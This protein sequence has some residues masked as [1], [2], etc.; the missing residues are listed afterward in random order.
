MCKVIK[1]QR[2]QYRN[3]REDN[4]KRVLGIHTTATGWMTEI[5]IADLPIIGT[6]EIITWVETT[7]VTTNRT[8]T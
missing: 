6:G 7:G 2:N 3:K 1:E 4:D 8:I 5:A